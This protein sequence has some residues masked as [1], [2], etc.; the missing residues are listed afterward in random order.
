MGQYNA[1]ERA[2]PYRLNGQERARMLMA[3][4]SIDKYEEEI[5]RLLRQLSVMTNASVDLE[6]RRLS[7]HNYRVRIKEAVRG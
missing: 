3:E 7:G 6:V 5:A 1:V 4:Q 2:S